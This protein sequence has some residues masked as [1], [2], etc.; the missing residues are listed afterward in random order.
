M[1]VSHYE[2]DACHIRAESHDNQRRTISYL[3]NTKLKKLTTDRDI[4]ILAIP[5][6]GHVENN[7]NRLTC[8]R[9]TANDLY[10]FIILVLYT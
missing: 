9:V 7:T 3:S 8:L 6:Y 2:V 10:S 5:R 1:R 4:I